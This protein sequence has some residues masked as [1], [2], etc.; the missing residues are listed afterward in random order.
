MPQRPKA[1]DRRYPLRFKGALRGRHR[2]PLALRRHRLGTAPISSL[3][4][5][6][7]MTP[8][9]PG[10]SLAPMRSNTVAQRT[11]SSG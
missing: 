5:S 3:R 6:T 10:H 7:M 8:A 4:A 2:L 9:K 1:V 11:A